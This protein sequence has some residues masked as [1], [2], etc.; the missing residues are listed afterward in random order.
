MQKKLCSKAA[1]VVSQA[2]AVWPARLQCVK[3]DPA[4]DHS[5]DHSSYGSV[6]LVQLLHIYIIYGYMY[7]QAVPPT[8]KCS[9]PVDRRSGTCCEALSQVVPRQQLY[10]FIHKKLF[11]SLQKVTF[12]TSHLGKD[13]IHFDFLAPRQSLFHRTERNRLEHTETDRNTSL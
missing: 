9:D 13:G 2:C 6:P 12:L 5:C 3:I 8:L 10:K 7:T 4:C 11:L 1:K